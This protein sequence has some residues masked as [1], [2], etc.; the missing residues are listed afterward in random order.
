MAGQAL[1]L[2]LP[3]RAGMTPPVRLPLKTVLIHSGA[4]LPARIW[5]L[6]HFRTVAKRLREKGVS[7]QIACDPDQH[8]WWKKNGEMAASP[9]TVGELFNLIDL[10]GLFIG[11]CSGPGHLAAISGVP[12]FT[13]YGPSM[14]EWFAP[15]HPSSEVV[16]GHACPYKPC[17]DYC[18]YAKPFCLHDVTPDEVWPCLEQFVLRHLPARPLAEA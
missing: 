8:F 15:L 5:P 9:R 13:V 10:A 4:R 16:E 2:N 3:D 17:S 6:E 14:H 1:G 18:R 7:V 12:T 11:N